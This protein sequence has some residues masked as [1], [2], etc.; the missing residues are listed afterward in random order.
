MSTL[1]LGY[2]Q[3]SLAAQL[4]AGLDEGIKHGDFF[5]PVTIV[6]PNRYLGKW[7]RLWLAR[8]LGI[9]INL[10]FQYLE[11]AMWEM[12]RAL[13]SRPHASPVKMLDHENY[14]L[15]ILS[16][17]LQDSTDEQLVPLRQYLRHGEEEPGRK[18]YRRSWQLADRLAGLLRDY[19]YHRQAALIE[20]WQANKDGYP[21]VQADIRGLERS[22]RALFQEVMRQPDGLAASLGK[23]T[24][25]TYKTLPQ[26]ANEVMKLSSG[27]T[28]EHM[29]ARPV[30]LFGITQI[31]GLH[32]H[33]LRW[34][35]ERYE[36]NLYH[37]NPLVGRLGA[38]PRARSEARAALQALADRFRQKSRAE[39]KVPADGEELLAAWAPAGAESLWL[40]AD[41]LAGA[42]AFKVKTVKLATASEDS[43]WE[44]GACLFQAKNP[45]PQPHSPEYRGEGRVCPPGV[46][47]RLQHQLLGQMPGTELARL[48]PD[49][50][51]QIVGCPCIYREVETAYQSILHNLHTNPKL[52]Q[53]DIALLVTDMHRYRPVIQ[54]VFD[55][56]P[57]RILYNLADFSAAGLSA[58]GQAMLGLLD[59]ALESFSRSRVFG[60]LLNPCVLARLGVEREQASI[61]LEWAE[62]LGIYHGWDQADKQAR[63]YLDTPFYSWRLGLQRLRLG[64]LMEATNG[65]ADRPASHFHE[66]VPYADIASADKSQM[67]S[68]CQAVEGLLPVLMRLRDFRKTG[69]QWADELR[70]LVAAF[71]A[72][73]SERPEEG[74][75]RDRLLQALPQLRTLDQLSA[76]S[77]HKIELP[78]GLVREFVRES[79]ECL[80][81]TKGEYLT[82]GVT[83]SALQPLRPVPFQIIYLL[84]MGE[85]DFPGSNVFPT[86]DLRALE[87]CAGD[88]RLPEANRFLLLEAV[89]AA[90]QKLY[91][92][93]NNKELQ[94]DQELQPCGLVNQLR[95]YLEK[96]VVESAFTIK[97]APLHGS[98]PKLLPQDSREDV[99]VNY[100]ATER[101]LAIREAH[102]RGQLCFDAQ[103]TEKLEQRLREAQRHFP[104][105][106]APL[107]EVPA[108][109]TIHLQEL[110][111]FLRCPAEAA[112]KRHLRLSDEEEIEPAD[113]EPFATGFP[114]DYQLVVTALEQFVA[115]AI[116]HGV[117]DALADWRQRFANL[118]A[119]WRLRGKTPEGAFAEVD[120]THFEQL[121]EKRILG[122]QGLADFLHRRA[123][124]KFC[125]PVVLGESFTPVGA[126]LRLPALEIALSPVEKQCSLPATVRLVGMLPLVWQSS[127]GFE[128]LIITN[129]A[130]DKVPADNLSKPLL[131]PLLFFFALMASAERQGGEQ[132]MLSPLPRFGGEGL[133]ARGPN[134]PRPRPLT[135]DPSPRSTGARGEQSLPLAQGDSAGPREWLTPASFRLHVAQEEGITSFTYRAEDITPDQARIY[136][137]GLVEDF[138]NRTSFDLLPFDVVVNDKQLRSAFTLPADAEELQ[139]LQGDFRRLLQ[140]AIERDAENDRPVYRPMKLMEIIEASIPEDAFEKMRRRFHL[141]DRGPARARTEQGGA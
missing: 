138:L 9:A 14:R 84:G 20:K 81:G 57:K 125:G 19:E 6:V 15:M 47:G 71:L 1:Y 85:G 30:H 48:P 32:V 139:Q 70:R 135:P 114:L 108:A 93:Y 4:A 120:Q 68:F 117:V 66:V 127:E 100:N 18:F 131:E 67:D 22:E 56:A 5:A 134:D 130:K 141:L 101:L 109:L 43:G 122:E 45:H 129:A 54:A 91:L 96:Y 87:R 21:R 113:C 74:E 99:L 126:R 25:T 106:A 60:V 44:D 77:G 72:I 24:D 111:G 40:M 102:Q 136:L 128:A 17:L 50:T 88:I 107:S 13:D 16:V 97:E 23:L 79:L 82:G 41:L 137:T 140:G 89:L 46:L 105:P 37:L 35:G 10:R 124:M 94:R 90:R 123:G 31:S 53:T 29:E 112:L 118:Y 26:Y 52:K 75:V 119:E 98:D 104:L 115:R 83:M 51:L 12:L 7:L 59:L 33:V 39:E 58:F 116:E 103:H 86:L 28:K 133:G 92:L 3:D 38:L 42:R 55:R 73:P 65:D 76:T 61:W 132:L 80:E 11:I 63:G 2:D 8:H 49:R 121:L 78:L 69:G 95:R 36:L 34:L 62:A 64:R 27:Q 110:R